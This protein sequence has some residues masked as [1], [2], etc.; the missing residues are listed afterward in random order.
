MPLVKSSRRGLSI[1]KQVGEVVV[2]LKFKEEELQRLQKQVR[3]GFPRC[4]L[5]LPLSPLNPSL[6]ML[7]PTAL[8]FLLQAN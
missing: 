6:P 1:G 8:S 4:M 5:P 3:P 7:F 2:A